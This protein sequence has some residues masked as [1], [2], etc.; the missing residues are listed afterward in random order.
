MGG[1]HSSASFF[2][3]CL[4]TYTYEELRR[5]LFPK[6]Y[7]VYNIFIRHFGEDKVDLQQIPSNSNIKYFVRDFEGV[8]VT[9]E[10]V[11]IPDDML[12]GIKNAVIRELGYPDE[13]LCPFILIYWPTV[14]ITNESNRSVLIHKLYAKVAVTLDG[15]IPASSSGFLLNRAHYSYVQ[16]IN[17][18]MHSH[19]S[20]IPTDSFYRFQTPCLGSGPIRTTISTLKNNNDEI[21]WMLFCQE[22]GMYVTVESLRGGPYHKM[23]NIS[24]VGRLSRWYSQYEFSD[25]NPRIFRRDFGQDNFVSFVDYYLHNNHL[26][27]NFINNQFTI[28]LPFFDYMID[29]SNAFIQYCNTHCTQVNIDCMW[30]RGILHRLKA[31][32]RTLYRISSYSS[33]RYTPQEIA[34]F[35]GSLVCR[36]KGQEIRVS[37][38]EPS[39]NT[40]ADEAPDCIVLDFAPAMYILKRILRI[41]NYKYNNEYCKQPVE[42]RTASSTTSTTYKTVLYV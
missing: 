6:L 17:D 35:N 8:T 37:I 16:F 11:D 42:D 23:E 18:Y 29:I 19:I 33:Y 41:I 15:Y 32:N 30:N 26:S 21:T 9:D 28:S 25:W 20:H 3:L 10:S 7:E 4:M 1:G 22:L 13:D 38:E 31:I 24:D 27:F 34:R 5:I 14:N 36:F 2:N 39:I 40:N 12:A